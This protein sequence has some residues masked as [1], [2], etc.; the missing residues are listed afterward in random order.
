VDSREAKEILLPYRAGAGDMDDPQVLAALEQ[1][2]RDPVLGRWLERHLAAQ[3]AI[4]NR[5]KEI[6]IP[7]DLKSRIL[8]NRTR[9]EK[10]IRFPQILSAAAAIA[11][12]ISLATFLWPAGKSDRFTAFRQ[13]MVT[14]VLRNY[15]MQMVTTNLA[16]VRQFLQSKN[17]HGDYVLTEQLQKLP[18]EGSDVFTWHGRQV[19]LICLNGGA[20]NDLYLFVV[21]RGKLA[22]APESAAPRFAQVNKL[23]TA[24]WTSGDNLYLLAGPGDEE[25]LRRYF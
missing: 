16:E 12:L 11:L 10:I 4:R 2:K 8:S 9:R 18:A 1:A 25:S 3:T 21:D 7:P 13:S 17:A 6:P 23:M 22:G 20:R 15:R 19:S 24:T 5:F 14:R